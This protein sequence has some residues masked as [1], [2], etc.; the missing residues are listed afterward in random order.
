M[1]SSYYVLD[2]CA[3]CWGYYTSHYSFTTYCLQMKSPYT[4]KHKLTQRENPKLE[5]K[6][7]FLIFFY[8][9]VSFPK[10]EKAGFDLN[11]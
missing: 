3:S 1:L 4:E 9:P 6:F 10:V 2:N 11:Y 7:I 8:F 5:H